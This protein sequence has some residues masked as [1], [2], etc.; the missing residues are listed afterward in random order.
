MDSCHSVALTM[1]DWKGR[2][3]LWS[4]PWLIEK[5]VPFCGVDHDWLK[6]PLKGA[7][8]WLNKVVP[9]LALT[10][11]R[12]AVLFCGVGCCLLL[13]LLQRFYILCFISGHNMENRKLKA[14][15]TLLKPWWCSLRDGKEYS[16]R[17]FISLDK[18][19]YCVLFY[20]VS[21]C[22]KF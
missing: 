9:F 20:I 14:F 16:R 21:Y 7:W 18:N 6:R 3:V 22:L 5:V 19:K 4:W 2:A 1:I 15:Q 8:L 13:K 11:R 17:D 12:Q 10:F